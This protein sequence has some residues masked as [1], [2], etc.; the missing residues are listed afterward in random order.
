MIDTNEYKPMPDGAI[1]RIKLIRTKLGCSLLEAR[2]F[3]LQDPTTWDK[4]LDA[5]I[6]QAIRSRSSFVSTEERIRS[7]VREYQRRGSLRDSIRAMGEIEEILGM[8]Q[9]KDDPN[10]ESLCMEVVMPGDPEPCVLCQNL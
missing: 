1:S 9:P 4:R 10:H 8:T 2:N 7:V 6:D 5:A 3:Y